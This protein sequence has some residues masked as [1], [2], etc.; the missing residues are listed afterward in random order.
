MTAKARRIIREL[1]L[2]FLEEPRLLPT[3]YL[4]DDP[5]RQARAISDYLAGMTDRYAIQEH[6]NIFQM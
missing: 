5:V 3:D 4:R 1:F 6:R 2:A